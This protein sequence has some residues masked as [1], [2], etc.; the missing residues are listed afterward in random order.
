MNNLVSVVLVLSNGFSRISLLSVPHF[1]GC[2]PRMVA[3]FKGC[4]S[5]AVSAVYQVFDQGG[6]SLVILLLFSY[7]FN[8][9]PDKFPSLLLS[10]HIHGQR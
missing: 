5:V 2:G 10:L 1:K 8:P 7:I 3:D 4:Q 6:Y 9:D